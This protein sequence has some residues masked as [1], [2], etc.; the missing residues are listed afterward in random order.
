MKFRKIVR[1]GMAAAVVQCFAIGRQQRMNSR[2]PS[3]EKPGNWGA[4]K[5]SFDR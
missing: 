1:A 3:L 4:S 2:H 5:A